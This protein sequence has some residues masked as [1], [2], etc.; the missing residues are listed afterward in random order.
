MR[1]ENNLART[2]VT[3]TEKVIINQIVYLKGKYDEG[4]ETA[5][6][7]LKNWASN[8]AQKYYSQLTRDLSNHLKSIGYSQAC[9][10]YASLTVPV[11]EPTY[12][13]P[14]PTL[15][16]SPTP[17]PPIQPETYD[18][19]P[20]LP[21]KPL[22]LTIDQYKQVYQNMKDQGIPPWVWY[23]IMMCESGGD[24][25]AWNSSLTENS[26]GLFQINIMANPKYHSYDLFNPGI[27][28]AL[29]AKYWIK[30]VWDK[31][32]Y[33]YNW[34]SLVGCKDCYKNGVLPFW[35]VDLE[36]KVEK[37]YYQVKNVKYDI[38]NPDICYIGEVRVEADIS[39]GI[40]GITKILRGYAKTFKELFYKL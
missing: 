26:K 23:P 20:T 5:N 8:E 36:E 29:I 9:S 19:P 21:P 27:N 14:T 24:P 28:A 18:V 7:A 34:P 15:Q 16:P 3:T 12:Q 25:K 11:D 31:G 22:K 38:L 39:P 10:Y 2:I 4:I 1:G 40:T 33:R 32:K 35:T 13:K 37:L 17:I 30:P 6:Q